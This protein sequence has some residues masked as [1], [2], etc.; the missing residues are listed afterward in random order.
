MLDAETNP[1]PNLFKPGGQVFQFTAVP[2]ACGQ[3][4]SPIN[5]ESRS[6][7]QIPMIE[8]AQTAG[9]SPIIVNEGVEADRVGPPTVKGFQQASLDFGFQFETGFRLRLGGQGKRQF[10]DKWERRD[11]K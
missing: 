6:S 7:I 3:V 9:N 2:L 10:A 5:S 11:V 8:C 1:R 4:V